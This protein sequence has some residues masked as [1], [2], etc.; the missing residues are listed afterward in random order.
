MFLHYPACSTCQKAKK[1]LTENNIDY[2]NRLIVEERPTA[3][4][5][6][7]WIERSGLPIKR[8]FNTSGLVYKE[9]K[10]SE[11]L[12]SMSEEEQIA[13]LATNGKLVKRPLLIVENTV[14]VGFKP[15]DWERLK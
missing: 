15:D 13:L 12:P 14:L 11:K 6:K 10:L 8:F 3:A 5:L 1:W 4:E 7:T 9:L 2:T